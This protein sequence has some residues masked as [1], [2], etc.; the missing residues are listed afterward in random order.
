[1]VKFVLLFPH[2]ILHEAGL[3]FLGFGLSPLQPAIGII[4]SESIQYIST[5]MWWL[6]AFPGMAL[7]VMVM[8]FESIGDS[9]NKILNSETSRQ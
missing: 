3:T 4:L 9:L 2:V 8:C 7:L 1:M 5:G 6:V